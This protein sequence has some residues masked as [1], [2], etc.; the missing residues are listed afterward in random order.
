VLTYF[1]QYFVGRPAQS[2]IGNR[3]GIVTSSADQIGRALAEILI[4]L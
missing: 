3:D 4:K 1:E 2:L